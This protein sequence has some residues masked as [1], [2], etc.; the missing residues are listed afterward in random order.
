MRSRFL[1]LLAVLMLSISL[2]WSQTVAQAQEPTPSTE[3]TDGSAGS[4]F[5]GE[6]DNVAVAIVTK[7]GSSKA[8]V[9][10]RIVRTSDDV[11][12]N[13]NV[14]VAFASC[15]GCRSVAIAVQVVL[16]SGTPSTVIPEN[17]A[18][19]LNFECIDCA[20]LASAYQFVLGVDGNVHFSPEGNRALAE[21]RKQ[22]RELASS[23]LAVDELQ[24]ELDLLADELRTVLAEELLTAGPDD[25]LVQEEPTGEAV[26]PTAGPSPSGETEPLPTPTT[27]ETSELESS[28]SPEA[29]T[30]PSGGPSPTPSAMSSP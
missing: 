4:T 29:S 23:E 8:K 18:I 20:T 27:E 10:F 9:S 7:D 13:G 16:V 30:T 24:G 14:A 28:P 19:A 1:R 2:G 15:E 21:I 12:D 6:G 5:G 11:I 22:I 26:I 3:G 25:V 17:F